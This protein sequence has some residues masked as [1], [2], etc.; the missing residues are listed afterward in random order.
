MSGKERHPLDTDINVSPF[1]VT[2]FLAATLLLR[3]IY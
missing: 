3:T 1:R 2:S